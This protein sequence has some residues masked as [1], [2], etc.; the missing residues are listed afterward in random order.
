MSVNWKTYKLVEVTDFI[1][2]GI[3]PK[4]T[5]ENGVQIINQR[6]IRKNKIIYET[7]RL[8]DL[9]RKGI[10]DKK[11]LKKFDVLVNSTGVGTLGRVAQY[12]HEIDKISVDS[13]V[14]IV[15]PK[16]DFCDEYFGYAIIGNQKKIESLGEGSTGQTELSRI[17]LGENIEIS[18]PDS[19]LE[20][21]AIASILSA[22]DDKIELNLQM[23]K[24]LEAMAMALYKHWFV[25]F[26]PFQDM[27]FVDSELGEI[28][29]GW[30]V[31]K[32]GQHFEALRGL[33][34]K[35]K[36]LASDGEGVPMH[37][38]NSVFEG[39][40][41]KHKGLKWYTGDFKERHE[42]FPGDLIVTNTEQGFEYKLIGSPALIPSCYGEKG[43]FSHHLYLSLIHI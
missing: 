14:S 22:L 20:R 40:Y 19:K 34:Y 36:F 17:R 38:L 6:C 42:I 31:E 29:K 35:G 2:R 30:K 24:T 16:P 25:D 13:H 9:D 41:Y 1:G 4:Y 39:G 26:G 37:N 21:K 7:C 5:E 28:P 43:I 15:R 8:H 32:L 27:E 33:S 18:I 3:S 10:S 12:K 11:F 23:N